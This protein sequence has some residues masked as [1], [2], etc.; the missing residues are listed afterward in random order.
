MR[1]IQKYEAA[2]S[3]QPLGCK[4]A[5]LVRKTDQWLRWTKCYYIYALMEYKGIH[6]YI[7]ECWQLSGLGDN[8]LAI[9]TSYSF[10]MTEEASRWMSKKEIMKMLEPDQ[11][12]KYGTQTNIFSQ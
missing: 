1:R 6:F 2:Y 3:M 8:E 7:R 11:D 4:W 12:K 10:A 9:R 5:T